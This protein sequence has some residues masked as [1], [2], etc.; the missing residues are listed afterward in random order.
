MGTY[1][2]GNGMERGDCDECG[3]RNNLRKALIEAKTQWLCTD[4][5]ATHI[6][7]IRLPPRQR[8]RRK[9]AQPP[10]EWLSVLYFKRKSR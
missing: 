6:E 5:L 4:C 7:P 9:P 2:E 8:G 10:E 1:K 3:R